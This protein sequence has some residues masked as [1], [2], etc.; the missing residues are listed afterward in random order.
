MRILV[1]TSIWI[2]HLHRADPELQRLLHND[3]VCVAGPILGELFAGNLPQRKR[4]VAD[5]RLLPRLTVPP[6]EEV[7]EWIDSAKLAGKGLSWVD[8][9]LL[10]TARNHQ[11]PIW[12][13]DKALAKA[14]FNEE[15]APQR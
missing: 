1:D 12:T 2:D 13:R 6:D 11:T 9:Q 14:A 5:L 7:F 4:T 15:L 10:A 8:C 3:S